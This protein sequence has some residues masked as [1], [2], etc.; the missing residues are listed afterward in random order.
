[1]NPNTPRA[2]RGSVSG[3]GRERRFSVKL[4]VVAAVGI[5]VVLMATLTAQAVVAR[6]TCNNH[7]LL[8]NVAVSDDI[9]PAV[10][11]VG[12][13]F[14]RQSHQVNGRCVEVQVTEAPPAT[15]AAQVDG[16]ASSHGLPSVDAWIPDS[17]LWVNVAR[18]FPLGAQRVQTTGIVVARS[19]LMIVMPAPAAAQVPSFNNAVSWNFLLPGSVG[20]PPAALGLRVDLPDPTQSAA[21]LASLVE[22]S[23]LLGSGPAARTR[24]TKFAFSAQS[25]AQF[26]DP[27][28]L[29][30]F[31][32]QALPPLSARPVT[33][34]SEQAVLG[35]DATHPHQPL[36]AQYPSASEATL[37]TPELN[38]PYLITSTTPAKQQAARQF[39][40]TL[41][42]SFAA[43]V[44][45]YYGFRSASGVGNAIPAADGIAEQ[46]MTLAPPATPSE[47]QTVLQAW[48]KLQIGSRDLTL[49]D[50]SAAMAAP[51]G[52]GSL[53]LEQALAQTANL[54]LT[55][56]PDSAQI[57]LWEMANKV[58]GNLPYKQLVPVGPLP[59]K[60]GL[61]SRRQQLVQIDA[62]LLPLAH[63]PLALNQAILAAYKQMVASYQPKFTNAVIVMTAGVGE[64]PGDLPTASLVSQLRQLYNSARPVE[65]IIVVLGTKANFPA[66]QQIA[67][68]GGGAAYQVTSPDQIGRVFFQ[69]VS[70][71]ICQ[72]GCTAP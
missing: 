55:L 24:L 48:N 40:A 57:G 46:P 11:R 9:S 5:S 54:G 65:L 31:S 66:L 23:R 1:V 32:I 29:A 72:T 49:V 50:T 33:V 8:V 63:T 7:P 17:N 42:Q 27:A 16:Q 43:M 19:P 51:S 39:G 62:S 67:T 14:N 18:A 37:G 70:R 13:Y 45:R 56:F 44:V 41:R 26:S 71:R 12:Q 4:L 68:A 69:A 10:Q 58:S 47:A 38:Y 60:L 30:A 2:Q 21:G 53:T 52:V 6:T 28:S 36:A 34:T 64:A 3:R 20:G 25:S 15:V 22:M 61:I 35:Y 59:D